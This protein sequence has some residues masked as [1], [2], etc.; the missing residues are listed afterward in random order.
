MRGLGK[1]FHHEM[2]KILKEKTLLFGFLILPVLTLFVTVGM[3]LLEPR[4]GQEE[5]TS[6]VMY[7]YGIDLQ[8]SNIGSID[9]KQIWIENIEVAPEEFV[10]SD[11]FHNC[12][13]LVDFSDIECVE[14]YYHESDPMSSYLKMS[15]NPLSARA[16]IKYISR[17]IPASC[18]GRLNWRI[19]R[20]KKTRTA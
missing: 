11:T 13:V 7:F 14:I 1:I 5:N 4:T 20:R 6:Y 15:A 16:S 17:R 9:D 19:L 3:T 8:R 2:Q 12:D 10:H 18:S